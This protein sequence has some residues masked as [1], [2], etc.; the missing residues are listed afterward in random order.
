MAA[1]HEITRA[2]I[3]SMSEYAEERTERRRAIGEVKRDRRFEIGP[4]V[5]IYFENYDTMW[6]QV[7]EMLYIERGGEE[8]IADE[9]A[10]Y[11]PLIPNGAD[12]VATLM[13]EI[14]QPER[15]QRVLAGLGGVEETV[16]MSFAGETITAVPEG[17]VAR[18][19][20]EG[21]ASS[22]HFLHFPFTREQAAKFRAP[23]AK[24][25]VGIGHPGYGHMAAMP[26]AVRQA[27]MHDFD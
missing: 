7:H 16:T 14:D 5:T 11:N 18:S 27:L 12:L 25:V 4:F 20:A 8:Q 23:G 9:L 3:M 13:F 10:A 15:R 24:V 21:R 17:D 19:T 6:W 26:E 22:V 2:D 1:K